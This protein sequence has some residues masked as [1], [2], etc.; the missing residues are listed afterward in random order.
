M[1]GAYQC[2]LVF[3]IACWCLLGACWAPLGAYWHSL[4]A[5]WALIAIVCVIRSLLVLTGCA[6]GA[7]WVLMV[8]FRALIG[9]CLQNQHPT[10]IFLFITN[11]HPISIDKHPVLFDVLLHKQAICGFYMYTSSSG[12]LF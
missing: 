9:A 6:L 3:I 5:C 4:G 12:C 2:L 10:A 8:P 11:R 7:R 1:L